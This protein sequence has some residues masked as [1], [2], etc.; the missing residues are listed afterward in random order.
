MKGHAYGFR[1]YVKTYLPLISLAECVVHGP[2]SRKQSV[3]S[4]T[5]VSLCIKNSKSV[6]ALRETDLR[7]VA[8]FCCDFSLLCDADL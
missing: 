3:Y 8:D 1:K 5:A 2:L 7:T 6:K 4:L